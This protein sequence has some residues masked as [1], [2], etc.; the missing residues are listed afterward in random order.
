[1]RGKNEVFLIFFSSLLA[2]EKFKNITTHYEIKIFV[3]RLKS[4]A[5]TVLIFI[6]NEWIAID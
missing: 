4:C 3:G 5:G 1:L 2:Y 6:K